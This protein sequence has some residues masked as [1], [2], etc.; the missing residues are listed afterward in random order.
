LLFYVV[1]QSA[2]EN[3]LVSIVGYGGGERFESD[4]YVIY[5]DI[6]FINGSPTP[7]ATVHA[8]HGVIARG[9]YTIGVNDGGA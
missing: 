1:S 9:Q 3:V 5:G 2:C 7:V 8:S 6:M 4:A